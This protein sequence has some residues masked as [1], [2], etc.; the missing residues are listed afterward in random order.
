[1]T[2]STVWRD[3][4]GHLINVGE[5]DYGQQVVDWSDPEVPK[6][7]FDDNGPV[8]TNPL[9]A[10]AVRDIV[11]IVATPTGRLVI[12]GDYQAY[13]VLSARQLRLGLLQGG[14]SLSA[15]QVAIDGIS[16][17]SAREIANVEWEYATEFARGHHLIADV[18]GAL[19]LTDDQV[20][21]LWF[22]ASAL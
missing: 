17:E 14:I 15:V 9:P 22:G 5:W 12:K 2:M 20:D 3:A 7:V 21:D 11:E 1:M 19:G 16:D 6:L 13:P 10:G 8:M 18:S 4:D